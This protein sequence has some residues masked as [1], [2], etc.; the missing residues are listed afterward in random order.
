MK[1]TAFSYNSIFLQ[2]NFFLDEPQ[3]FES[4]VKKE[5]CET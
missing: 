3:T 4:V 5:T 1:K 2:N